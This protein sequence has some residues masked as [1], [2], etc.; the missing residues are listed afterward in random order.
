MSERGPAEARASEEGGSERAREEGPAGGRA[1]GDRASERAPR[2]GGGGRRRQR[3]R[4]RPRAG[5][6]GGGGRTHTLPADPFPDRRRRSPEPGFGGSVEG[7]SQLL[8]RRPPARVANQGVRA[9][10]AGIANLGGSMRKR[11]RGQM[12]Q[13]LAAPRRFGWP[14]ASLA[15]TGGLLV[16]RGRGE[17]ASRAPPP[18]PGPRPSSRP[19]PPHFLPA[20]PRPAGQ[21]AS[22]GVHCLCRAGG[23]LVPRGAQRLL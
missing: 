7:P 18:R 13:R 15:F 22:P 20:P 10:L 23:M 4:R 2:G 9:D 3:R 11:R 12:P 19:G 14:R 5:G 1:A 21:G 17:R 6:A 8:T 16:T